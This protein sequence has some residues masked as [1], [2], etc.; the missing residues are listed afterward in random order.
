MPNR[1]CLEC[2]GELIQDTMS[3]DLVCYR[4]ELCFEDEEEEEN[5]N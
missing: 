2:K 1:E 5:F 3:S 4:C